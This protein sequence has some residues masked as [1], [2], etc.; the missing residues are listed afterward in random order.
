M[1]LKIRENKRIREINS[2]T[3]NPN[4]A[5]SREHYTYC[6]RVCAIVH[7]SHQPAWWAA[8][9][10]VPGLGCHSSGRTWPCWEH[11]DTGALTEKRKQAMSDSKHSRQKR[12]K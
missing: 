11:T 3:L 8:W 10:I 1:I 12:D 9:E 7:G 6:A 5:A 4:E 2:N